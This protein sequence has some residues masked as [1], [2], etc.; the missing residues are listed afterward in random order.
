MTQLLAII[1]TSLL[2]GFGGG[3]TVKDWKD[4][5]KIKHLEWRAEVSRAAN[6]ECK[7]DIADVRQ[8]VAGMVKAAED[9]AQKAESAM[10]KA[11]DKAAKHTA[12]AKAIREAPVRQDEPMCDAVFREQKEYV[13]ARRDS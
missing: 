2:V 6:V 3:W 4:G 8:S 5:S 9:R 12:A 13:Q 10:L 1:A 7:A 11:E